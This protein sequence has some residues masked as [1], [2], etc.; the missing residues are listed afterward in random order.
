VV[1]ALPFTP[2]PDANRLLAAEPFAVLTG[3]LLD[4]QVPME[5]A[6]RAPALLK[7][8][9][10]GRLDAPLIAAMPVEDLEA[11]FREKPALH[12][13]PGAMAKRTHALAVYLVEHYDGRTDRVWADATT[14]AELLEHLRSLPGFGDAKAR[15]FVGLLGKRLGVRP[16]GWETAAADWPSIADVDNFE[17]VSEIREQKRAVKAAKKGGAGAD[18]ARRAPSDTKSMRMPPE[19]KLPKS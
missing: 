3:M 4:Q 17:R 18:K 19:L 2:D 13:F 11:L 7:E 14:G 8:R 10:G 9:L 16:P 6:F 12:R 1:D 15:I 5:W